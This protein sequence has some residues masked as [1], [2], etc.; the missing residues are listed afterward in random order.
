M[1]RIR[2]PPP[3]VGQD[4][5]AI[6]AATAFEEPNVVLAQKEKEAGAVQDEVQRYP[7]R[8]G[9]HD[10]DKPRRLGLSIDAYGSPP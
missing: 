4:K 8:G 3:L 1:Q 10:E 6:V 9:E 2:C 7:E 5:A